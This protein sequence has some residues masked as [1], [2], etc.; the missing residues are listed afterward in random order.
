MKKTFILIIVI[1]LIALS[2][3]IYFRDPLSAKIFSAYLGNRLNADITAGK[4]HLGLGPR[5][6]IEDLRIV[7]SRGL[8]CS[9]KA[10]TL[11]FDLQPMF[12]KNL[13]LRFDLK[14]VGFSYPASKIV[15]S[16]T[17]A[18]SIKSPQYLH[19]D[20]VKGEFYCAGEENIIKSLDANGKLLRLFADGSVRGLFIDYSF[21]LSLSDE[22]T[23]GM[24]ESTRKIFFK[25]D[26]QYSE[27]ELYVTGSIDNPSVN[28]S[29]DLFKLTIR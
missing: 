6:E 8:D 9:V 19:F 20:Y 24:P 7:N 5:L 11:N 2:A 22:L 18:L 12:S 23:A 17:G 16:I 13:K 26:S 25:Q 10:L 28:F 29:T 15:K 27:I 4:V 14:D 21:K 3:I 1:L